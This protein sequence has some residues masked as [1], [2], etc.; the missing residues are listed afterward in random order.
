MTSG[1][2]VVGV[3]IMALSDHPDLLDNVWQNLE[4]MLMVMSS[5]YTIWGNWIFDPG[6]INGIDDDGDNYVDN[7]IGWDVSF[8]DN[9]PMPPNNQ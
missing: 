9:N 4:K 2:I 7:F 6:D 1:E 3:V 8:N 5:D